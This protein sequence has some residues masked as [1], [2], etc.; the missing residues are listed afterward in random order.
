MCGATGQT[1]DEYY[2]HPAYFFA[3]FLKVPLVFFEKV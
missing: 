2:F 1:Q 3:Y